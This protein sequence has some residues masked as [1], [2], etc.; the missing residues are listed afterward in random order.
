M[1][2]SFKNLLGLAVL[3]CMVVSVSGE[4]KA[5]GTTAVPEDNLMPAEFTTI[6]KESWSFLKDETD[7]LAKI[8][9]SKLEFETAAEFEKRAVDA[10]QQ[11]L[12]KVNRYVKDK[13]LDTRVFG[14]LFKAT[15]VEY[16]ADT[17]VYSLTSPT[18]VEAP[19][20]IPQIVTEVPGNPYVALADS[21]TKGYRTSSIYLNF[22]PH[23]RWQ[24]HRD[25]A[26]AA[27]ADEAHIYFRVRFKIELQQ[28]GTS[29]AARFAIVPQRLMLFNQRANSV[30]W[31]QP[32]R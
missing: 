6:L 18:L 14:V 29:G 5:Q 28:T 4:S 30:Y 17:R 11:Y 32:L 15:L 19:Y 9:G 8:V 1:K 23:F 12:T 22:S 20:N 10:R 24:A 2:A 3:G 25:T 31:E 13:K 27:K 21:I 7:S 16:N 26:R